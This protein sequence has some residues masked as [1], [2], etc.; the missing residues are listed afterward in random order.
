MGI[1]KNPV[2]TTTVETPDTIV[3][4]HT[5]LDEITLLHVYIPVN[6][7]SLLLYDII[8]YYTI[9][10]HIRVARRTYNDRPTTVYSR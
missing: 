4:H 6:I 9:L 1:E 3:L 2:E 8:P 5:S 7:L 10:Y